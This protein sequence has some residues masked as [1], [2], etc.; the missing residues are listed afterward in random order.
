[1]VEI[2]GAMPDGGRNRVKLAFASVPAFLAMK[3]FAVNDR[4]KQKDVYD[5]SAVRA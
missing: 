4:L 5:C 3:G 1:M 2:E